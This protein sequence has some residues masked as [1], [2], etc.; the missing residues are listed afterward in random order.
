M[1]LMVIPWWL[2]W[3]L[4]DGFDGYILLQCA[5]KRELW[6]V[7]LPAHLIS[8]MLACGYITDNRRLYRNNQRYVDS[9][10]CATLK[11]NGT[12]P[13]LL[14]AFINHVCAVI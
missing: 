14:K 13:E 12:E 10:E 11:Y 6:H 8:Y 4:P 1:I 7:L 3:L 2:W 9:E 5:G